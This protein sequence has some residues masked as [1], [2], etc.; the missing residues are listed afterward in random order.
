VLWEI[1][2]STVSERGTL[3]IGPANYSPERIQIDGDRDVLTLAQLLKMLLELLATTLENTR[4]SE[5]G[6]SRRLV[7]LLQR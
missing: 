4:S 5:I 6:K 3:N 2:G 1:L 7:P